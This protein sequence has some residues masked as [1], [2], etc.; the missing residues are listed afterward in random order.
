ME[1]EETESE[2]VESRHLILGFV[3]LAV[4][5]W[6][7]LLISY[8]EVLK[9]VFGGTSFLDASRAFWP[10]SWFRFGLVTTYCTV[11]TARLA[12]HSPEQFDL[13][14]G[15][16][17]IMYAITIAPFIFLIAFPSS[18]LDRQDDPFFIRAFWVFCVLHGLGFKLLLKIGDHR[19]SF[20]S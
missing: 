1:R 13:F 2:E 16:P 5:T 8:S 6:V 20:V 19:K 9:F 14:S 12:Y 11:V 10:L 3:I 7:G 17:A 4:C 15:I 18:S